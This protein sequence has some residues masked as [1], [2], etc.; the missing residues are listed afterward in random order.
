MNVNKSYCGNC[1]AICKFCKHAICIILYILNLDNVIYRFYLNKTR[2]GGRLPFP[3]WTVQH[4]WKLPL[5]Q[6]RSPHTRC[7]AGMSS[8]VGTL[9]GREGE[10]G[11]KGKVSEAQGE[12]EKLSCLPFQSP[13]QH[14]GHLINSHLSSPP[15]WLPPTQA[16]LS[17]ELL[18]E[19]S[20]WGVMRQKTQ[21][22][23]LV[24]WNIWAQASHEPLWAPLSFLLCE[25]K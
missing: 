11:R 21:K 4:A 10:W 17:R 12:G 23:W 22:S 16:S 18:P 6:S 14:H 25:M 3:P 1:F 24:L 15:S 20:Q 7:L 13:E 19:R 8:E 5:W 9:A 2:A